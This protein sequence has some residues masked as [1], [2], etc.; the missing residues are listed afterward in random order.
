MSDQRFRE[1][2][3]RWEVTRSVDDEAALLREG[4]RIGAV[5]PA[6]VR[7]A[8][9]FGHRAAQLAGAA[10]SVFPERPTL[11]DVRG[12]MASEI[13]SIASEIAAAGSAT[14]ARAMAALL[15]L[16]PTEP[17]HAARLEHLRALARRLLAGGQLGEEFTLT[18]VDAVGAAQ[19]I[20][21]AV[22][23]AMTGRRPSAAV[24]RTLAAC[25]ARVAGEH[26]GRPA[27]W[28]TPADVVQLWRVRLVPWLLGMTADAHQSGAHSES[29]Q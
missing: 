8:A 26:E 15:D 28:A 20:C 22:N 19:T 1:L 18:E 16:I 12:L 6:H 14:V 9:M 2:Q 21:L 13:G 29:G 4:L 3:R 23:G 17:E 5:D 24:A 10:S 27:P 25:V 11:S 7:L